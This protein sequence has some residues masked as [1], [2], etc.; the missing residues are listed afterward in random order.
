M[1]AEGAVSDGD[2]SKVENAGLPSCGMDITASQSVADFDNNSVW[3]AGDHHSDTQIVFDIN[4][5]L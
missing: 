4:D 1:P 3:H 2:R 5:S